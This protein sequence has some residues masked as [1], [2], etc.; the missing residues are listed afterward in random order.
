MK[1]VLIIKQAILS[2]KSYKQMEMGRYV[3]LVDASADKK[4][5]SKAV[6]NQFSVKVA[7]VNVLKRFAKTRKIAKTRKTVKIGGSKKAVV[8]LEKG[9]TIAML[10]PKTTAKV[11]K[12]K[13]QEKDE[14]NKDDKENK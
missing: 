1:Q 10:S 9:Q 3:F 14:S 4:T 8:Y 2:E 13:P 5:I 7:K 12:Q 6:E 11:K